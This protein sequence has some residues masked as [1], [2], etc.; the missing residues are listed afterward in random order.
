MELFLEFFIHTYLYFCL[1]WDMYNGGWE[2]RNTIK[3]SR[4]EAVKLRIKEI[5]DNLHLVPF[6]YRQACK[7]EIEDIIKEL[8]PSKPD[9]KIVK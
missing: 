9:L 5:R 8:I 4:L 7:K 3:R 2:M 1:N 6:E